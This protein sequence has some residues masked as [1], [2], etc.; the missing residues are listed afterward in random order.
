[1]TSAASTGILL[2]FI[3]AGYAVVVM[4]RQEVFFYEG[5][6]NFFLKGR[7]SFMLPVSGSIFSGATGFDSGLKVCV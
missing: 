7:V 1:M 3:F 6:M 5:Y 4:V 2:S